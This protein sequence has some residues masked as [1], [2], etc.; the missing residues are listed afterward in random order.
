MNNYFSVATK[1]NNQLEDAIASYV[2]NLVALGEKLPMDQWSIDYLTSKAE[3]A[4]ESI[5]Q[6]KKVFIKLHANSQDLSVSVE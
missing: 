5:L 2:F 6:D 4:F 1:G 3:S